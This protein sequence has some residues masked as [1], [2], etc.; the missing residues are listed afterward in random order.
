MVR[1]RY[2]P[3]HD[4]RLGVFWRMLVAHQTIASS[5]PA[6]LVPLTPGPSPALGRGEG[7][8]RAFYCLPC[9]DSSQ[10]SLN[11]PA[12]STVTSSGGLPASSFRAAESPSRG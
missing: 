2:G 3:F 11:R 6:A 5:S 1:V 7:N 10:R 8:S 12:C 9:A 4:A